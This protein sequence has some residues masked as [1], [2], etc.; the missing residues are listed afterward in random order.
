MRNEHP[1]SQIVEADLTWTGERFERGIRVAI[2]DDGRILELR[3]DGAEPTL[4]LTDEALLPGLINAHSHAFQRA[5]RGRGERFPFG[6]GSFWSWRQAMYELVDSLDERSFLSRTRSAF[7]E[8][9][10]S[11]ITTVGEFHYLH[12]SKGSQD[13]S[14][15]P[16]V[17]RAAR[18]AGVRLVLL[19]VYYRRGSFDRPLEDIQKRFA[20]SSFEE[21][22]SR[23]EQVESQLDPSMQTVGAVAH[24]IRAVSLEEIEGLYGEAIRRMM[25]FHMHVEEQRRE[26]EECVEV[27][28]KPPMALL[29]E[30]LE[31]TSGFTAVHCTHTAPEDLQ[32][33][34]ALGGQICA[35]PL[36]EGNLG[37][38]VQRELPATIGNLCL[39]TDSN[40][41]VGMLEEMRWLEY[42]QRLAHE[43]RGMFREVGGEVAR[44]LLE[45]ATTGGAH[46]LNVNA[47]SIEA[48]RC[49][50]FFSIDLRSPLLEGWGEMD[51][52]E[53]LVFGATEE[54]IL[55]TCVNGS[56]MQHREPG[57]QRTPAGFLRE[58]STTGPDE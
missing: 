54:V 4:R 33:F 21:F 10:R 30:R 44:I 45:A 51:L 5:L 48:G 56:W 16:L 9:R 46:A 8:M 40:A 15:D 28:G 23:L 55:R 25:P 53:S 35:T 14:F 58:S 7:R 41:R 22:W 18:D 36:T 17:A 43:Q 49:A 3:R 39:G 24:S 26:I 47:G 13:W 19:Q 2:G 57:E 50:D 42:T 52:L 27:H 6:R 34:V 38:G 12:H 29:N 37:D 32:R 11:G 31:I 1:S 20:S